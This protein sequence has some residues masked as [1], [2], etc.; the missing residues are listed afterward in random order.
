[1][2][3]FA[4][5]FLNIITLS[6]RD[7]HLKLAKLAGFGPGKPEYVVNVLHEHDFILLQEH[8]FRESQFHRIINIL[9]DIVTLLSHGV[10]A[11][12]SNVLFKGEVC[13]DAPLFGK[14]L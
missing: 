5:A 6:Y 13:G 2:V 1:M 12:D 9:S 14:V 7:T 11:A 10:S 4:I 8:W 3:Y